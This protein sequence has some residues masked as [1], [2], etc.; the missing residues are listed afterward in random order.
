M[1]SALLV[2]CNSKVCNTIG[3]G[4]QTLNR[5]LTLKKYI[6]FRMNASLR[7]KNYCTIVFQ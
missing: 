6:Y 4:T 2:G 7:I 5:T 1:N 3:L